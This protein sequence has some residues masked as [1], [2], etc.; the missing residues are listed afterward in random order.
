MI[1]WRIL[2]FLFL[3]LVMG[4]SLKYLNYYWA[5]LI[6]VYGLWNFTDGYLRGRK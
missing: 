3:V 1:L 6:F 5:A 4:L 2:D